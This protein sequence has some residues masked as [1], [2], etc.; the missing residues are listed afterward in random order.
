M[1]KEKEFEF[2][3]RVANLGALVKE[4]ETEIANLGQTMH[5]KTTHISRVE[6]AVREKEAALNHIYH[7][8]GWRALLTYY[9]MRDKLLPAKSGMRKVAKRAWS[10][11]GGKKVTTDDSPET[12]PK[13]DP[14]PFEVVR[15]DLCGSESDESTRFPI[16]CNHGNR[17]SGDDT[18]PYPMVKPVRVAIDAST[19]CQLNC[20]SCP[21]ASGEIHKNIGSGFLKFEH[22][23][24]IID[25]NIWIR[26]VELSNWGEIFLNPDLLKIIEYAYKKNVV[27][28]ADN[29]VNLNTVSEEVLEA[30]VKYRFH[31]MTCSIDGASQETYSIYRRNGDFE[32]VMKHIRRINRYKDIYKSELPALKWQFVAFGHNT[33]EIAAAKKMADDLHMNFYL[34]LSWEDLYT[35]TF[36]PVKEKDLLRE[37]SGIGVASRE[38]YLEKTGKDYREETC[39]HLFDQP[40][41]N[42]DGRVL[43]CSYNYQ[44]DFGNAFQEGMIRSLNNEK[45]RYARQM[46]LGIKEGRDDIPCAVCKLFES[47]KKRSAWVIDVPSG[48]KPCSP[49]ASH[50]NPLRIPLPPPEQDNW[51]PY[52]LFKE[53]TADIQSLSC[54]ASVLNQGHSPHLPHRH[55]E[56]EIL[57]LLWGEV[58]LILPDKQE[59]DANQRVHLKPG[60]F[61]YC[62][63]Q[64]AH[65]IQTTSETPATYVMFAWQGE[66]TENESPLNF[67]HFRLFESINVSDIKGGISQRPVFEGPTLYLRKLHCHTSILAPGAGYDPHTDDY[68]VAIVLLEGE[69][70]TLGKHVEPHSV[71]FYRA[72]EPHGMRNPGESIAKYVVFEFRGSHRKG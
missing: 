1:I 14:I 27:L 47:R 25:E 46:L 29:G 22:F 41:I 39:L 7:S 63:A 55:D 30:L 51:K 12:T 32:K 4:K 43:G 72:G 53:A 71:I 60:E 52:P 58:D 2:D 61:V 28:R 62:P 17:D 31:S 37:E 70:E 5:Q 69:V 13:A 57:M 20:R 16:P 36:S 15:E 33:H 18:S 24:N 56:E 49:L 68:D 64:F 40:Q 50:V 35:P 26:E 19:V 67:C 65:T 3:Q 21:N 8:H 45:I 66:R 23:K 48:W 54:H 44:G 10:C 9:R 34:K 42:F 59:A 38:E 6:D 11:L